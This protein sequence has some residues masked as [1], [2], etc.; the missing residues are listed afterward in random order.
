MQDAVIVALSRTPIAKSPRGS[1][2]HTRPDD[3]AAAAI[4]A[5]LAQLPSLD[6]HEID[7]AVLGCS[8]PEGESGMNVARVACLRAGL[9]NTIPGATV[10]RFCASG[11]EAVA[12]AAQRIRSGDAEIMIA[13]GTESM[14]LVPFLGV[15][16]KPNPALVDSAPNTYLNMGLSVEQL[17]KKHGVTREQA[18]A[19]S[20]ASHEKALAAQAEGKFEA[21]IAPVETVVEESVDGRPVEKKLR[22]DKDEGPRAGT[23][24]EGLAKL[25]PAFRSDGVITAG[26]ASQRSD[27]A[28]IVILMSASKADKLGIKPWGRF[29]GYTTAAV[30]PEDFGVAPAYAVPKLLKKHGLNPEDLDLIEF[31]EAFAAQALASDKLYPL[32]MDRMNVNGGAIALGHP[33][34]CTGARQTVT[35][36]HELRRRSGKYGL[37][38]MCAALGMAGAGL[39]EAYS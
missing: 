20:V 34:G 36:F 21:E 30:A 19:F 3:L 18:D 31:N 16:T 11:L 24:L 23:T 12:I 17:S 38:T 15:S 22:A 37:V 27:G 10:N 32:P 28:A 5:A 14:T 6:F 25:R 29:V 1:F 9:P 33:L 35:L 4:K 26:N 7:D 39:F 2:R 13:G 8:M